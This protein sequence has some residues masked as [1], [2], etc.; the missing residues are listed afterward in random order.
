MFCVRS[1]RRP[2]LLTPLT[3]MSVSLRHACESTDPGTA[4]DLSTLLIPQHRSTR[5]RRSIHGHHMHA[6]TRCRRTSRES[7]CRRSTAVEVALKMAFKKF[8]QDHGIATAG[9]EWRGLQVVALDGG[10]HGDTLGVMDC[11]PESVFNGGQTPWYRPRG[12]FITAPT[13]GLVRGAWQVRR[14]PPL[15]PDSLAG[16][17]ARSAASLACAFQFG[18]VWPRLQPA[19]GSRYPGYRHTARV[20]AVAPQRRQPERRYGY[21]SPCMLRRAY[22]TMH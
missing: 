5:L 20:V 10:Y 13:L 18:G 21:A 4:T 2:D 6:C 15:A 22:A 17:G 8:A 11:S 19:T 7:R 16:A 14:P 9:P 1:T 3:P 12:L